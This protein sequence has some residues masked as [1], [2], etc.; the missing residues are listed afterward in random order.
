MAD[1]RKLFIPGGL[2]D[3]TGREV[4]NITPLLSAHDRDLVRQLQVAQASLDP[5]IEPHTGRNGPVFTLNDE[6]DHVVC[7]LIPP[8]T[9]VFTH[10]GQFQFDAFKVIRDL[11]LSPAGKNF[12]QAQGWDIFRP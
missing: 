9:Y 6:H 4:P 7:G 8:R 5:A 3:A 2:R 1:D 12:V 11:L 10:P